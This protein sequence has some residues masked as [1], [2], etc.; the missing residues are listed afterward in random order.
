MVGLD[1]LGLWV[2]SAETNVDLYPVDAVVTVSFQ[3]CCALWLFQGGS[4]DTFER[5]AYNNNI[6]IMV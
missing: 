5:D 6:E 1:E 3:N 4:R 2:F